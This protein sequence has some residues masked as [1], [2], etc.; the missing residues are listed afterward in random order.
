[1]A[2][3]HFEEYDDPILY[4]QENEAYFPELPFLLKWAEKQQGIIVDLA[5]GTGRLTIPLA[6]RGYHLAGVDI[7]NG[8]LTKA[9]QKSDQ[10]GVRIDWREQ[11]CTVLDL[12]I[13]SHFIYCVGNSFQHFH[14]NEEQDRF[15]TSVYKHLHD[16]GIFIFGTRFPSEEELLQPS[17]EEYW[18]SYKDNEQVTVDVYTISQYDSLSQIQ[19]Y[20]TIRKY[21]N[22]DGTI[23]NEKITGIQLR[24]VF[25]KE[26]ERLLRSN[27]F[28]ILH[29]Y[30]DW[31][32][33]EITNDSYESIYVCRK[34]NS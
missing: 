1:M 11:D 5:C 33:S 9:K 32:E 23:I 18:R 34:K 6:K 25:P 7:H 17:T 14:S 27:G 21:K 20:T 8:M 22:Q 13:K 4:D 16:D 2:I 26:M 15:L 29:H 31:Q 12:Q 10:H 30:S 3:N 28:E 24:Y 19:H